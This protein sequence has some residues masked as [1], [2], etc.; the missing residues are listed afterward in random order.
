[1]LCN[2]WINIVIIMDCDI[3][4]WVV[5][6]L[7]LM[8]LWLDRKRQ[9]GYLFRCEFGGFCYALELLDLFIVNVFWK[10]LDETRF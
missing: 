1:M 7:L 5:A 8:N 10:D 2:D 6:T 4:L 3:V 9:G